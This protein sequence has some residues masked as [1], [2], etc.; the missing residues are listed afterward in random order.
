MRL[1]A[2]D[3]FEVSGETTFCPL[4]DSELP[5][6]IADV[7]AIQNSLYELKQNLESLDGERPRLRNYIN[8]LH[9]QLESN[10]QEI[11]DCEGAIEALLKEQDAAEQ[12]R[13]SNT[14]IA[15][16]VGRISLYLDTINLVDETSSLRQ[17]IEEARKEVKRIESEIDPDEVEILLASKLN[18]IS[19]YMTDWAEKLELEYTDFH[20][21]LDLKKLT[22][23]VDRPD[24]PISM[25]RMGSGQNWLGSHLVALLAL[26]RYFREQNRPVPGFIILDQPSQVYFLNKEAYLSLE[27]RLEDIENLDEIDAD[28]LSVSRM[29]DMFFDVCSMLFPE[30]QIIVTEHANLGDSRFQSSLV[31]EPWT[32]GRALIPEEWYL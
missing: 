22:V 26:H 4:C 29:F 7:L 20:Y 3:L 8:E 28:L 24:R 19:S 17:K 13:D 12:M 27:G 30:F 6:P 21:R 23:M 11:R 2:I 14:R 9:E 31:E 18:I 16:V 5:H 10:R 1:E 15:R 32:G 25:D